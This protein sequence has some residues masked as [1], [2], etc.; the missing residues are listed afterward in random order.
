M[1]KL[2]LRNKILLSITALVI[3]LTT[4]VLLIVNHLMAQQIR[5]KITEDFHVTHR[6][7]ERF[8]RLRGE[9]LISSSFFLS[10]E[11][12]L[13]AALETKDP[14]TVLQNVRVLSANVPVD[15]FTVTNEQ[16]VVLAR[17]DQPEK[18]GDNIS[19]LRPIIDALQGKD[20]ESVQTFVQN[21]RLYQI[22]SVSILSPAIRFVM[23]TLTLG[24]ELT[25]RE[26][27][28]LKSGSTSDTLHLSDVESARSEISFLLGRNIVA[29]T[30]PEAVRKD[31]LKAYLDIED[32]LKAS[33]HEHAETEPK[34]IMIQGERHL[35]TFSF[36][37]KGQEGISVV[38]FSLDRA[39][40]Q[41]KAIQRV[42][43]FVGLAGILVAIAV[44]YF[45]SKGITAP[46]LKVVDATK[47]IQE[48]NYDVHVECKTKDEIGALAESFNRMTAGLKERFLMSKFISSATIEMIRRATG[49]MLELGGERRNVT[50][51]FSDIRG[52]TAFSEQVEPEVVID[53]LNRYLSLQA[54]L[55]LKHNG[56][57]DKYV[58]DE[59]IAIFEGPD[60]VDNAVQCAMEIQKEIHELNKSNPTDIRIG[61]GINTGM[62]IVGN[63]GSEERMDHTVLGANMNLGSRL[64][65]LANAGQIIISESSYRLL[66][67]KHVK[68]NRLEPILVKGITQPVQTY[69]VL[70]L[71]EESVKEHP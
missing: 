39:L 50:V 64:C 40:E 9:Q 13:V 27:K 28:E 25:D 6:N 41:L 63:V 18:F 65:S 42:I 46:V 4:V 34:E 24:Y 55:V 16:G 71:I 49:G 33:M 61:I 1:I 11:P 17:L 12:T 68:V 67:L 21:G 38:A 44:S 15:I 66:K 32:E 69:E 19:T 37:A 31:L 5:Q 54:K 58:G 14:R 3:V 35:A 48:G 52:F 45:I 51:L 70:P 22:A 43:F 53:L 20:L 2:N 57:I 7:F 47:R 23:G 62:A 36:I 30:F 60:M 29:S 10:E 56:I 8:L 59:L 26:A